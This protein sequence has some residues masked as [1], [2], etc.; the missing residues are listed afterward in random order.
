L[1]A[2]LR[3]LRAS[4][5]AHLGERSDDWLGGFRVDQLLVAGGG[6]GYPQRRRF[7]DSCPQA[8]AL[9]NFLTSISGG[10]KPLKSKTNFSLSTL[11]GRR[12]DTKRADDRH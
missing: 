12:I 6:G 10:Q 2:I 1:I 7:A 4:N 11:N 9:L 3:I 5:F 8:T